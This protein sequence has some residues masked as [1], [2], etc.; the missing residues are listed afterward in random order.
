MD[1]AG[2]L[3]RVAPQDDASLVKEMQVLRVR[4]RQ[5]ARLPRFAQEHR[6]YWKTADFST[7]RCALRSK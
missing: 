1:M 7:S 2:V 5:G 3:R 6:I 4:S